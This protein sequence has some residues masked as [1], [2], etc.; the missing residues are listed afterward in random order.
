MTH[1]LCRG[2]RS[3]GVKQR[4]GHATLTLQQGCNSGG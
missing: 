1:R 2:L 3:G 4:G